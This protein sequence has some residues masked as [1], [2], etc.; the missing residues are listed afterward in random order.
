MFYVTTRRRRFALAAL[1]LCALPALGGC[2]PFV[3]GG[4][5]VG[6]T[7][8]AQERPVSAAVDDTLIQGKIDKALFEHDKTIFQRVDISVVEGKVLLTGIVPAPADRLDAARLSW[9]VDGVREVINE[10]EVKDVSGLTNAARDSWISA[11]LRSKITFDAQVRSI[12]Y[13]IDTVNRTVYLMGIAQSE[14]ELDRVIGHARQ[15]DYVRRVVP[16]V[17]IKDAP[18]GD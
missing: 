11:T 9:K 3:L 17:R 5:A 13:T 4:A 12:N 1:S 6:A 10:I 15:V 7:V 2:G 8:A 16:Y 14:E 18:G